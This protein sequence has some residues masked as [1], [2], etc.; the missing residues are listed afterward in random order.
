MWISILVLLF[1]AAALTAAAGLWLAHRRRRAR[2][3]YQRRLEAALADGMLTPGE[4]AELD[5]IR[6]ARDLTRVEVR[7]VARAIYRGA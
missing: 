5:G 4:V 3:Y 6:E 2:L 1:A 7:M